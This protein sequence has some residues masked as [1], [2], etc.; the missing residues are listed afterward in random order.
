MTVISSQCLINNDWFP[1][2]DN[3]DSISEKKVGTVKLD[4]QLDQFDSMLED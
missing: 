3:L 2:R 1:K 4:C